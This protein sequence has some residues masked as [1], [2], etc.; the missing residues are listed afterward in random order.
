MEFGLNSGK[1]G[2]L[3]QCHPL[4]NTVRLRRCFRNSIRHL[5]A[6]LF[7]VKELS[8]SST[9]AFCVT[10]QALRYLPARGMFGLGG[11]AVRREISR[12]C[13]LFGLILCFPRL[14]LCA[15]D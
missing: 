6:H 12:R 4:T 15:K 7:D 13:V 11:E 9:N 3:D 14:P 5:L 10:S 1:D 8:L 2:P